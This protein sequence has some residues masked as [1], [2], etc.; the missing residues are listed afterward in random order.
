MLKR[1][2]LTLI[3]FCVVGGCVVIVSVF[4]G[5]SVALPQLIVD[6]S[7]CPATKCSNGAC[8]GFDNTPDPDGRSEMKCPEVTCSSVDCHAWDTLVKRYYQPSDLSLNL[9]ILAP[10]VL[11]VALVFLVKKL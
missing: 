8:H 6:D 9:W 4:A 7:P 1:V 11:V 10:V 3:V 5:D 2:F